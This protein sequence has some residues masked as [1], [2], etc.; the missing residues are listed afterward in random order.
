MKLV[1]AEHFILEQHYLETR[2]VNE[3]FFM[4]HVDISRKK[5]LPVEQ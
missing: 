5:F 3:F 2:N 1:T 4:F